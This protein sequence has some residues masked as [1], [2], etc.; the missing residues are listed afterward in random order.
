MVSARL[1]ALTVECSHYSG[2][3][4]KEDFTRLGSYLLREK[5]SQLEYSLIE[6]MVV[7]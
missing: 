6:I 7:F 4:D 3:S 5:F 2:M 1:Y